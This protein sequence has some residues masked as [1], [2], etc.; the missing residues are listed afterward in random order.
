MAALEACSEAQRDLCSTWHVTFAASCEGRDCPAAD[1]SSWANAVRRGG[2]DE[3][4]AAARDIVHWAALR[5]GMR[6]RSPRECPTAFTT[7]MR[8]TW[9]RWTDAVQETERIAEEMLMLMRSAVSG[10]S[11]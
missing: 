2:R 8:V 9:T 6:V 4:L 11:R 3:V 5:R 1:L 7:R 10:S